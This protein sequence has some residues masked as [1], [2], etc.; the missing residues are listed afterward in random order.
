MGL[1][2]PSGRRCQPFLRSQVLFP[3]GA[4][5]GGE[6]RSAARRENRLGNTTRIEASA[7]RFGPHRARIRSHGHRFLGG[8]AGMGER[9]VC[10]ARDSSPRPARATSDDGPILG[11]VKLDNVSPEVFSTRLWSA[12]RHA[13]GAASPPNDRV[14]VL[15]V[16]VFPGD[17]PPCGSPTCCRAWARGCAAGGTRR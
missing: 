9:I 10:G 2:V 11:A 17:A 5:R 15:V 8:H 12:Q 6:E 14:E 1:H 4:L 3:L 16:G 13:R 7:P